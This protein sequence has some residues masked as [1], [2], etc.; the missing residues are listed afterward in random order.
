VVR[1]QVG[2]WQVETRDGTAAE[3]HGLDVA[4]DRCLVRIN[5]VTRPAIVLGSTQSSDA[6]IDRTSA[7]RS[8]V[9]IAQRHSG[10]GVVYLAPD[11]QV[12]VDVVVP[13]DDPL[14][15]DDVGRAGWWL[16]E[17][18]AATVAGALGSSDGVEVHRG[19]VSDRALGRIACFAATGPGEVGVAGR[20]VVGV[21]Q[22]RTR[23]GARFQCAAPLVWDPER[24]LSLLVDSVRD[25]ALV[26]ALRERVG[27]LPRSGEWDVVEELVAR[28][29]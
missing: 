20:K 19:G 25:A 15:D 17:A 4:W 18:W 21:S 5:R 1:R 3:L 14:W 16:G 12:W 7:D 22:R 23:A 10:G 8:G 26:R 13:R 24:T 28:L 11:A 29:P 27:V 6:L 2:R 9:E